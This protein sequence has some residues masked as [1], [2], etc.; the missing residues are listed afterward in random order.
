[1]ALAEP[2]AAVANLNIVEILVVLAVALVVLGP[3]RLPEVL[4]TLGKIVR[5]LRSASNEVIRELTEAMDEDSHP[6]P[7]PPA[8]P[9]AADKPPRPEPAPPAAQ[10]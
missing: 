3:E 1:L 10:S 6:K 8:S 9:E 2:A 5:E 4:R 7:P